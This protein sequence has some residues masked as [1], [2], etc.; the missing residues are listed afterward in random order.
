MVIWGSDR[1]KFGEPETTYRGKRICV[2]GKINAYKGVLEVV[3]K[4]PAQIK[5]Q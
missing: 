4:V 5:L 2:T 3:A 1:S